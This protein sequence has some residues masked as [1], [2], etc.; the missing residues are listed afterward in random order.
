[1]RSIGTLAFFLLLTTQAFGQEL[2]GD[3]IGG[4]KQN[5]RWILV[6]AQFQ[7]SGNSVN[8]NLDVVLPAY[9]QAAAPQTPLTE[10]RVS[11]ASVGFHYVTAQRDMVFYG[12]I[13]G[14]SLSGTVLGK[15]GWSGP[16]QLF[17]IRLL[18]ENALREYFGTYQFGPNEFLYVQTWNETSY[19]A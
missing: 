1:M 6:R 14:T 2:S 5:D 3:W 15:T 8:G 7:Q 9:R 19:F 10:L 16:F 13:E 4:F 11:D 18:G 17:H 12:R